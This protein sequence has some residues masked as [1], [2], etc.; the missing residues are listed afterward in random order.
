MGIL[1]PIFLAGL[2]GLA[3][4]LG[5]ADGPHDLVL[6][7]LPVLVAAGAILAVLGLPRVARRGGPAEV[8]RGREGRAQLRSR[9]SR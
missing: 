9:L 5:I 6:A 4:L 1:T 3:L 8:G 2:A 7:G